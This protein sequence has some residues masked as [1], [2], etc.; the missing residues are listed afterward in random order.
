M[1]N[2]AATIGVDFAT[3]PPI[4]DT[5]RER[6]A[7]LLQSGHLHRCREGSAVHRDVAELEQA[8]ATLLEARC[9]V[10]VN[11]RGSALLLS[12]LVAAIIAGSLDAERRQVRD[13]R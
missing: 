11:Y 4:A 3:P 8:F 7:A 10:A 6:A 5:A 2:G 9:A 13:G 12:L 1:M